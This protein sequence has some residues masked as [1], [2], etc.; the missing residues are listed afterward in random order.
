MARIPGVEHDEARRKA[1]QNE[2]VYDPAV[3]PR[4]PATEGASD[5]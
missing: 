5:S 1:L 3:F 2:C 4:F